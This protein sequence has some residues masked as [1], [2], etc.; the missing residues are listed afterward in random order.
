MTEN[1]PNFIYSAQRNLEWGKVNRAVK[2]L[3]KEKHL[4]FIERTPE[5]IAGIVKSQTNKALKYS[6][7]VNENGSH[8]CGT[9]NLHR[10][11]GL[12][13]GICKHGIM[14]TMAAVK[15]NL[16][17][18]EEGILWLQRSVGQYS[19][20]NKQVASALFARCESPTLDLEFRMV[21]INPEDFVAF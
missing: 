19:V 15:G 5:G 10:C 9:Q 21:E 7:I 14:L 11:G 17:T 16:I 12:R 2:M 20:Y 8:V 13:G 6:V 18:P 1:L 3:K 4:M